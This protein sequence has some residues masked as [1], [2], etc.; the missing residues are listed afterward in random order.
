[1]HAYAE[2]NHAYIV[3]LGTAQA[4]AAA[5]VQA[6]C[7]AANFLVLAYYVVLWKFPQAGR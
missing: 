3:W 7:H 2:E 6:H 1:M 4:Y 5:A